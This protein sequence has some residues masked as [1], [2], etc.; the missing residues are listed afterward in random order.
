METP[1]K[2]IIAKLSTNKVRSSSLLQQIRAYESKVLHGIMNLRGVS[3]KLFIIFFSITFFSHGKVS[4]QAVTFRL[5]Q[6]IGFAQKKI[7]SV[8]NY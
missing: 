4:T 1:R 3:T 8:L 2:F 6:N 5:G 7:W